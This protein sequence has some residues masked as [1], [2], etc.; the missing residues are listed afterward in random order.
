M[1]VTVLI[2]NYSTTLHTLLERLECTVSHHHIVRLRQ[3]VG[4]DGAR[5]VG[6]AGV[7]DG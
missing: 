2:R 6:L 3:V 4:E 7:V 5:M 1:E